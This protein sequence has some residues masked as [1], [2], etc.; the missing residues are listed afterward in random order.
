TNDGAIRTMNLTY[1]GF[2]AL[3]YDV[4]INNGV[5]TNLGGSTIYANDFENYGSF[6]SGINS[7]TLQ[8]LTTTLTN[9]S[10]TAGGDISIT[11][12]SLVT[13]NVFFSAG[14]GLTLSATTELTDDGVTNGN[15]WSVGGAS[16]V[17]LN[18]PVKPLIGDLLGTTITNYAPADNKQTVNTWAGTDYGV[19]VNGYTNNAAIGRLILDAVGLTSTFRFTGAGASN[20]LY[21]DLLV[22]DGA[23]TNGIENSYEFSNWLS[24][25]TNL[26]IYFAQATV[27]GISV[28]DKI[29]NASKNNGKNGGR[30]L[31][32]PAYTGYFSSTN[33]VNPDGTTNTYN[34]ALVASSVDSNG[35]GHANS[36]D[37]APFFLSSEVDL[38]LTMTNIPPLTA[39]IAWHSIPSATN[40]VCY[41]TNLN[42]SA[43]FTLTNF[44][45]PANTP[46]VGGWPITNT[47][48][49]T[50]NPAQPHYYNVKVY[51]N[52]S[53][54]YGQ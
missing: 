32:V 16:L 1:F 18:L 21:V 37:P 54:L 52:T 22:L 17:G 46:P 38:T 53:T 50:I 47:I 36:S 13:S 26:V 30:L 6:S 5:V 11:T 19:S 3:P 14:R 42:S 41:K 20:A 28:A 7:F 40:V 24:I 25:N 34:A 12:G 23:L 8:S 4:F 31:W 35:D 43:W 44:V 51:P 45:S 48:Y 49:D 15:I 9:G 27:D 10:I 29:N 33:F 39:V 2:P